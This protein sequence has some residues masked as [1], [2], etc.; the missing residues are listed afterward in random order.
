MDKF[1]M[2][3]IGVMKGLDFMVDIDGGI[4]GGKPIFTLVCLRFVEK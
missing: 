4:V 2:D 3:K 1:F